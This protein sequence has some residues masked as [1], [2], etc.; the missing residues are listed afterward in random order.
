MRKLIRVLALAGAVTSFADGLPEGYTLLP[1]LKANKNAQVKTGYTPAATDKIVMTWCPTQTS[2]TETLWCA[3]TSPSSA[4]FT[5][6]SYYGQKV[7]ITING[8]IYNES[9]TPPSGFTVK[10]RDLLAA[11]T[12]YTVIADGAAKTLAVTNAFTGAEVVNASWT[13]ANNFSV[14]SQLCLFAS[15]GSSAATAN[16]N[17]SSHFLYSFKVYDAAGTLK[18]DLV[19][20]KNSSG[21]VGLYDTVGNS[22]KT[23][24]TTGGSLTDALIDKTFDDDFTLLGDEVFGKVTVAAG[25]TLDLNGHNLTV[26]GLAG[27]GTITA[28][29]QDLTSPDPNAERVT[30]TGTFYGSTKGSNLFNDNYSRVVDTTNRIIVQSSKLPI[31]VT[32]D[33]G[34]ETPQKVD[35]YKIYCGT[36]EN[37]QARG[38]KSWTFEGADDVNGTWTPLHSV[39]NET[40]FNTHEVRTYAIDNSTAYRYYRI[41][42]TASSTTYLELV[43]LEY[44]DTS[45]GNAAQGE[46]HVAVPQGVESTN[47]TVTIHGNVKLVKEGEGTFVGNKLDQ[48]YYGGN[49]VS[50]G[51]LKAMPDIRLPFGAGGSDVQVEPGAAYD[52]NGANVSYIYHFKMNGGKLTNTGAELT[53]TVAHAGKTTLLADSYMEGP[54]GLGFRRANDAHVNVD[55]AGHTL[56]ISN[57]DTIVISATTFSNGVVRIEGYDGI[58]FYNGGHADTATLDIKGLIAVYKADITVSNLCLRSGSTSSVSSD[59]K[60]AFKVS[61][62]FKTETDDFPFVTMMDGSTLDLKDREGTLNA[63]SASSNSNGFRLRFNDGAT[64]TIDVSGRTL[65]LGDQLIAWDELPQNVTFQFDAATAEGGVAPVVTERGL[66]YGVVANTVEDAW[67]T[68]GAG[69]GDVANPTNWLC[70]NVLGQTMTDVVPTDVTHVYLEGTLATNVPSL[71]CRICTLTNATL[72]ADSDLRSL[73]AKLEI[74]PNATVNLNGK[75]LYVSASSQIGTCTVRDADPV[76]LTSP[77][78]TGN[79]VTHT[80][81]FYGGTVGANLFNNNYSRAANG[82]H[83]IIVETKNLPVS[84]TYDFGSP[85]LVDAYR[86]WTG[87]VKIHAVCRCAGR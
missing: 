7:G 9:D 78:T 2:T 47:S 16:G 44:F 40:W 53:A 64:V 82:T 15:H 57:D 24:S 36:W 70:K 75:K 69:N 11:Y 41:T 38:P 43:Q 4:G 17:Y 29:L 59:S 61:G 60:Y 35:C 13:V 12:K 72:A 83:R 76:D 1:Y 33:F 45:L 25:K 48:A 56:S 67:W 73:G 6:F 46:L 49:L 37:N 39:D 50:E 84:V 26:G 21:T 28:G 55:L 23:K 42:F 71:A 66:L 3:R 85:T 31:S 65:S 86:I 87:P 32:Y 19:P 27:D 63:V 62:T 74:A 8:T 68:G 79:H 54:F 14:G 5:A 52:F 30:Q 22:F 58:P 34:A 51:A 80:G 20:A 18:L 77:D 10:K 81:T